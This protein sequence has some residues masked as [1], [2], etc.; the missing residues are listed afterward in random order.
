MK[1][2]SIEEKEPKTQ[3][4]T[5]LTRL[6]NLVLCH[7]F[8]EGQKLKAGPL[9]D[10]LGVSRTPITNALAVLESEGLV[11]YSS[12]RGYT[13]KHFSEK[14]VSDAV[15]VRAALESLGCR[16]LAES[17]LD[18]SLS[19]ALQ[20]LLDK[21]EKIIADTIWCEEVES[22]WF[23]LN[24]NFHRLL[25]KGA[26]NH[27]LEKGVASTLNVP[28]LGEE[29]PS[30]TANLNHKL[31]A[32]LGNIPFHILESHAE[33]NRLLNVIQKGDSYMAESIMK[34]HVLV[35]ITPYRKLSD[36]L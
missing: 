10:R 21:E 28:I 36:L 13:A 18:P 16:Q 9:A 22:R 19:A 1:H 35:E 15:I 8:S 5:V 6:R 27:Y 29:P 3:S 32:E 23:E 11:S 31:K 12:N 33:H 2:N 20:Q 7:E 17:E 24:F 30:G 26:G 34:N 4:Q 14:D 25:L